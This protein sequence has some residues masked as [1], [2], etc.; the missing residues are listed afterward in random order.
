MPWNAVFWFGLLYQ[1]LS[2]FGH[3]LVRPLFW[4]V[5]SNVGFY[6]LYKLLI[7][8]SPNDVA[9]TSRALF[10]LTFASAVPF[11]AT[12]R[13]GCLSAVKTLFES[14]GL[15]DIPWQIQVASAAQGIT[16]LVLL[17]LLGLALRNH[18]KVQ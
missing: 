4:L 5:T 14:D 1:W 17:F 3:S 10:D 8:H 11:G 7:Q 18:F 15:T 2:D 16:N 13:P 12:A 6:Y 9:S